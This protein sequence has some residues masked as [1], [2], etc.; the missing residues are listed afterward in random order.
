MNWTKAWDQKDGGMT[1]AHMLVSKP[2]PPL[3][4]RSSSKP[5]TS[6]RNYK[7][8]HRLKN[9]PGTVTTHKKNQQPVSDVDHMVKFAQV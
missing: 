1:Q 5:D 6:S 3:V 8:G 7:T 9:E 4:L 2:K